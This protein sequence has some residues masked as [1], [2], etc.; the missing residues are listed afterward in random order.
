M[1]KKGIGAIQSV[2]GP[3]VDFVFPEGDV[4]EIFDAVHV[5]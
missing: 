1:T 4:P 2:I 5:E 3:V